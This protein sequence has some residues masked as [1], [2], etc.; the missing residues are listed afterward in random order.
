MVVVFEAQAYKT[1]HKTLFVFRKNVEIKIKANLPRI[2]L[3]NKQ[4][5]SH[6]QD[7]LFSVS[8]LQERNDKLV[9]YEAVCIDN[10]VRTKMA[11]EEEKYR[12]YRL[13]QSR[14]H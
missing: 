11:G 12:F 6:S 9:L 10:R 2:C 1:W 13:F 5:S 8:I 7:R 4:K 14:K 3:K